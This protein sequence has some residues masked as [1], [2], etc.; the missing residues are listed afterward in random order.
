MINAE[1]CVEDELTALENGTLNAA[2]FPHAE[3]VRLGYEMLRHY[4]FGEAVSRFSNGLKRLAAKNGQ[5]EK[6][7]DTITIAFLAII[8][9]RRA[10]NPE[11]AWP[12][13]KKTNHD[14]LNKR[15]LEHWYDPEQLKSDQARR[16]FCLPKRALAEIRI[17]ELENRNKFESPNRGTT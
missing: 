3:H 12:E 5:P 14:L 15:C 6:Y 9:E 10:L 7:H 4:E 13:F 16:T 11:S 1:F 17:S 2:S 8:A